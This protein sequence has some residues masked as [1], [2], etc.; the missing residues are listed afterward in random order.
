[1]S[2]SIVPKSYTNTWVE[3]TELLKGLHALNS[4][5]DMTWMCETGTMFVGTKDFED[6]MDELVESEDINTVL[7]QRLDEEIGELFARC[8]A[9]RQAYGDDVLVA[10]GQ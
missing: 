7:G 10:C 5:Y 3:R 2:D 8:Q 6:G 1:M 9:V 4:F